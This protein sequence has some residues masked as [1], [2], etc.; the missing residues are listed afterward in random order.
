MNDG[1]Y[2]ERHSMVQIPKNVMPDIPRPPM[3]ANDNECPGK[4]RGALIMI[5]H[6]YVVTIGIW[7]GSDIKLE[8]ICYVS[9][10]TKS[11]SLTIL[12][13]D[14]DILPRIDYER[15]IGLDSWVPEY[16]TDY[17]SSEY[18]LS[19]KNTEKPSKTI[20]KTTS[21]DYSIGQ[22]IELPSY[23]KALIDRST[24]ESHIVY[25]SLD[26]LDLYDSNIPLRLVSSEQVSKLLLEAM[27]D[28]I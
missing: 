10:T 25:P 15:N 22:T 13:T 8:A 1:I 19:T 14:P 11:E 17:L 9:Q 20:K 2:M 28:H 12:N 18:A 24:S 27:N 3:P 21:S 5:R 23:E 7:G 6:S 16:S 4:T 26:T